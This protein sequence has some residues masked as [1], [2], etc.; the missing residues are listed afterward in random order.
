MNRVKVIL[1]T[2]KIQNQDKF[3]ARYKCF[4]A[5]INLKSNNHNTKHKVADKNHTK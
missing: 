1:Q 3:K 2:K 4:K 5:N